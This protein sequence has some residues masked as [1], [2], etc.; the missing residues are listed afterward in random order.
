MNVVDTCLLVD[1]SNSRTKFALGTATGVGEVRILPTGELTEFSIGELVAD[2]EFNRV[3][4]CSVVPAA[5]GIIMN[6]LK[7]YPLSA[8]GPE[9]SGLVDFSHY[10]GKATLGADR[11]A[12]SLAASQFVPLPLVAVDAGTATTLDV[13]TRESS[14]TRFAGGMIVPGFKAFAECLPRCTA[15]LPCPRAMADA[16]AIGRTTQE[17]LS[18]G[19]YRGYAGMIDALI[20]DIEAEL[21][22]SVHVVLTGGDAE[23]LAPLLRRPCRIVPGLTLCGIALAAGL[24]V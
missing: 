11:I 24:P 8:V 14:G 12:N 21:A 20:N 7:K 23:M 5:G 1:N 19:V 2:W 16:P 18:A 13:V 17:A 3:C 22:E 4:L 9:S 15:Q 10:T 6:A